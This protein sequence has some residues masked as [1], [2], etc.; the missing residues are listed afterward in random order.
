MNPPPSTQD[1]YEWSIG[2]IRFFSIIARS[3]KKLLDLER[4]AEENKKTI[5]DI[6]QPLSELVRQSEY[7]EDMLKKTEMDKKSELT[8]EQSDKRGAWTYESDPKIFTGLYDL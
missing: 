8:N 5:K 1:L 4:E 3:Y 7:L 6:E 2:Q